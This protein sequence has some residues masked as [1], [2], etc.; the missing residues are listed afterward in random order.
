MVFIAWEG[1]MSPQDQI[2]S[3]LNS[4]GRRLWSVH[5]GATVYQAIELMSE[6]EIGALPVITSDGRLAGMLSERDYARKIILQG[7]SSKDTAVREI[8]AMP[9]TVQPYDSVEHCMRLMTNHRV[10]HLM[11]TDGTEVE[12]IVSIGDLVNWIISAHEESIEQLTSY[13]AGAYPR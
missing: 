5:P 9:V 6:R 13:I 11:V 4:K 2:G 8:M 10:R 3:V 1:H 12:G 7:R